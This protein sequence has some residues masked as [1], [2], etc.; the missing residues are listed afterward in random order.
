MTFVL[1]SAV[2]LLC[3]SLLAVAPVIAVDS[4]DEAE[5][6]TST[7]PAKPQ[8]V[9]PAAESFVP[10]APSKEPLVPIQQFDALCQKTG[11][12]P[13]VWKEVYEC[14]EAHTKN[15][16]EPVDLP[17]FLENFPKEVLIPQEP[18]RGEAR[19][20][21]FEKWVLQNFRIKLK[22]PYV[23]WTAQVSDKFGLTLQER[24]QLV[25]TIFGLERPKGSLTDTDL[26]AVDLIEKF[27][28]EKFAAA[29]MKHL[30]K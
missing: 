1:R 3:L 27:F 22:I 28:P 10:P 25:K 20:A 21:H 12:A 13:G 30:P 14:V 23:I 8:S 9:A 5:E 11:I 2:S 6:G 17:G 29:N 4:D 19:Q 7:P 26:C 15:S 18:L 24:G 16:N